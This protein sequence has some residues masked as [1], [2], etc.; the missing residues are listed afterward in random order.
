MSLTARKILFYSFALAFALTSFLII[1]YG[2]GYYIDFNGKRI[3]K[4][5][6]LH[7]KPKMKGAILTV[8]NKHISKSFP[9]ILRKLKPGIVEVKL[10]AE[11]RHAW[12]KKLEIKPNETTF[13]TDV[14]LLKKTEPEL[15]KKSAAPASIPVKSVQEQGYQN[16][17]STQKI[18]P[19]EML[20]K[21]IIGCEKQ[22][23]AIYFDDHSVYISNLDEKE[24]TPE[25]F[26]RISEKINDLQCIGELQYIMLAT[27]FDIKIIELDKRDFLNTIS[28]GAK[29]AEKIFLKEGGKIAVFDGEY[30]DK[31]GQFVLEL[32]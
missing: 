7:I 16:T 30:K 15:E 28:V 2:S 21:K 25:L 17:T 13:V 26:L 6:M 19:D 29:G 32:Y 9:I 8:N 12:S 14:V 31:K 5:G 10:E 27:E 22:K 23:K 3:T 11:G 1:L 24:K 18:L 4:T 20:D